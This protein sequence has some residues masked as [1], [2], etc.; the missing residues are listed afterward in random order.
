MVT[1][2]VDIVKKF[3]IDSLEFNI[4]FLHTICCFLDTQSAPKENEVYLNRD[5]FYKLEGL[6]FQQ[7]T[8]SEIPIKENDTIKIYIDGYTLLFKCK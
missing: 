8:W 2:F 5:D 4:E 7:P 1:A 3:E 6:T